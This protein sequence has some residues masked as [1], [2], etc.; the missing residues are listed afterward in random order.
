[1]TSPINNAKD[2]AAH[3]NDLRIIPRLL[4]VGGYISFGAAFVWIVEWFM[5]FDW[6]AVNDTG[7][8]LAIVSFPASILGIL[9]GVLGSITKHYFN[10]GG[11]N[12]NG[13]G[14]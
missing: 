6:T 1:V 4:V 12:G 10:T 14:G 7:V 5:A 3:L 2:M 11:H 9:T 13:N 8:A